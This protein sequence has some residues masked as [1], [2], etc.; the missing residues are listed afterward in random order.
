MKK[1]LEIPGACAVIALRYASRTTDEKALHICVGQG[2]FDS[3]WQKAAEEL[4]L[5]L[6]KVRSRKIMLRDFIKKHS[7]GLYLI[8][9]HNHL[10]VVENGEVYDPGWGAAGLRRNITGA[11]E[12][13]ITRG[14]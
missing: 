8:S 12:V 13:L 1:L 2:L 9:T 14:T 11:W 3:Q 7:T 10:F 4:G 6:T 5:K